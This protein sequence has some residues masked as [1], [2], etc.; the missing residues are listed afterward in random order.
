MAVL[1]QIAFGDGV[2]ALLEQIFDRLSQPRQHGER[3]DEN[4]ECLF[5]GHFFKS[6]EMVC[7]ITVSASGAAKAQVGS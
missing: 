3:G 2:P 4:S 7:L 6:C 1:R 5:H